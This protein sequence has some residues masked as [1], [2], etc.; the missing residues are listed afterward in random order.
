MPYNNYLYID[1]GEILLFLMVQLNY[2]L[3]VSGIGP[4]DFNRIFK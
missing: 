2:H 4:E 3:E 1:I